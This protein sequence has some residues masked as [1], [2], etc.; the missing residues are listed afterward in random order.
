MNAILPTSM[1][2]SFHSSTIS[3]IGYSFNTNCVGPKNS[4]RIGSRGQI[5]IHGLATSM[6]NAYFT[7]TAQAET[8]FGP[9]FISKPT[10]NETNTTVIINLF[11]YVPS[12]TSLPY[13]SKIKQQECFAG[14]DEIKKSEKSPYAKLSTALA[15]LSQKKVHLVLTRLYYP[16]LNSSIFSQ[17]LA[18]NAPSNTFL[19]FQEAILTYPSVHCTSLPAHIS[20]IKVQ[21]SGRLVTETVVPRAT[22]KSALIGSFNTNSS[23]ALIDYSKFTSKN[24]LGAFTVKV[25][26]SQRK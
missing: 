10:F 12:T 6:I 5:C 23:S 1:T 21:V 15:Q 22:V 7:K 13:F 26:I 11:Y 20:G 18:H 24:E 16:Y 9:C 4:K 8:G 14:S 17:Y 2:T 25:W 19:D 3:S